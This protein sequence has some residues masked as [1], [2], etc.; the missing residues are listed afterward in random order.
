MKKIKIKGTKDFTRQY[1]YSE[2][3]TGKIILKKGTK[4]IHGSY[5]EIDSFAPIE[6]CFT[7]YEWA[8][9]YG[10]GIEGYTYLAILKKDVEVECYTEDEVRFEISDENIEMEYIGNVDDFEKLEKTVI[11][12]WWDEEVEK[13][14]GYTKYNF[15]DIELSKYMT[16][17]EKNKMERNLNL[18]IESYGGKIK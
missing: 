14:F 12:K 9:K 13:T 18:Y 4:L 6:T 8:A 7:P 5:Y 10:L 17:R 11:Y 16:N 3:C 2:N 15:D 1:G